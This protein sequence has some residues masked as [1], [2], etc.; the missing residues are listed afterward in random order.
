MHETL[1]AAVMLEVRAQSGPGIT[2]TSASN[3]Y[4]NLGI[5]QLQ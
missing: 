3:T 5:V 1:A 2:G 4:H